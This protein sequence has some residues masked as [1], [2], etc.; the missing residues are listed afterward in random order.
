VA[1]ARRLWRWRQRDS[2]TSAVAW[3]RRGGGG[4]SAYLGGGT[5]RDG[6][7]VVDGRHLAEKTNNQ[8]IVSENN[9]GGIGEETQPGR[10]VR[11]DAVSLLW[12]SIDGQKLIERWAD[13]W[14]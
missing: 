8:P 14:P 4:G 6:G 3:Q 9:R 12:S 5:Q 11:G 13:P 7:S 1:A 10:N 2:A